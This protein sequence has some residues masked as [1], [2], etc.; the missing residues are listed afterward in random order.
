MKTR[1]D[2]TTI[3]LVHVDEVQNKKELDGILTLAKNVDNSA[4]V[5]IFASPQSI[6]TKYPEVVHTIKTLIRFMVVEELHLLNNF[7]RSFRDKFSLL[8]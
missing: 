1:S 8:Q 5:I 6:T 4:C 3:V 7:G 2:D